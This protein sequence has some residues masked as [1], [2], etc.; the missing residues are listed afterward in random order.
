M[1][2]P[3][4]KYSHVK[5]TERPCD[6]ATVRAHC[7]YTIYAFI[8]GNLIFVKSN[9]QGVR[10]LFKKLKVLLQLHVR[11]YVERHT[12]ALGGHYCKLSV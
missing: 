8:I 2:T 10:T 1:Q 9:I 5:K 3:S 11:I 12:W 7:S 4:A 6:L